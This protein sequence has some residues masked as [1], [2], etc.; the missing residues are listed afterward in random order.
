MAT[1][2]FEKCGDVPSIECDECQTTNGDKYF[3]AV[4]FFKKRTKQAA[5]QQKK[6]T[7]GDNEVPDVVQRS[8]INEGHGKRRRYNRAEI[9]NPIASTFANQ[10][11]NAGSKSRRADKDGEWLQSSRV[12]SAECPGQHRA[13]SMPNG[14]RCSPAN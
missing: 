4:P 3:P 12:R 2:E 11:P 13:I 8:A 5:E 10:Q 1:P 7:K 9:K 14:D 6:K